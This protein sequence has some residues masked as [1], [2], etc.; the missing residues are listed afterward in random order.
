[1]INSNQQ[2]QQLCFYD[3][4]IVF[5][6]FLFASFHLPLS[7]TI[8]PDNINAIDPG[9]AFVELRKIYTYQIDQTTQTTPRAGELFSIVRSSRELL[10]KETFRPIQ[11]DYNRKSEALLT[12]WREIHN[13]YKIRD[14][15]LL[16]LFTTLHNA[17]L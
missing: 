11:L 6:K 3:L 16:P 4:T 13:K 14:L 9:I 12:S 8:Q 15:G 7:T 1:M 2:R 17:L 5:P 10:T